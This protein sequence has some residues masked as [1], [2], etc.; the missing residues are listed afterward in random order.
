MDGTRPL[1]GTWREGGAYI[2]AHKRTCFSTVA[3]YN[4]LGKW[5]RRVQQAHTRPE[6]LAEVSKE[7]VELLYRATADPSR[8]IYT[9]KVLVTL[10]AKN[11]S[12]TTDSQMVYSGEKT[13]LTPSSSIHVTLKKCDASFSSCC[14][15]K[16]GHGGIES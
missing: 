10:A 6:F 5:K 1:P 16:C 15:T 9:R 12:T 11:Q 3:N 7:E 14:I 4:F 13:L 2:N 8:S